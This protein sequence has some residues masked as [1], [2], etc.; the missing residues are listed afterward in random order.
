MGT[1]QHV[2]CHKTLSMILMSSLMDSMSLHRR[3]SYIL[4]HTMAP[5]GDMQLSSGI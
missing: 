5:A 1:Y 2:V 4:E 3:A